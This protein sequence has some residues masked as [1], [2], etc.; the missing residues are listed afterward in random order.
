MIE[1][2]IIMHLK[3]LLSGVLSSIIKQYNRV[4]LQNNFAPRIKRE[5]CKNSSNYYDNK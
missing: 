1:K 4:N 3:K 5:G 2:I